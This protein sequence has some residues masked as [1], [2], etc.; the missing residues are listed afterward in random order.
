MK[1]KILLMGC[2]S[3]LLMGLVS[4]GQP[5][6][7][8]GTE[9]VVNSSASETVPETEEK[10]NE[11]SEESIGEDMPYWKGVRDLFVYDVYTTGRTYV[12]RVSINI[13][14]PSLKPTSFGWAY[15]LDPAYIFVT[16]PGFTLEDGKI[17]I[18]ENVMVESLEDTF[19]VTI[20]QICRYL[21]SDRNR[22]YS[23]FD[24]VVETA[25]PVTINDLSM[26][27]Y[28]GIH[29]YT[30]EEE[31][32]QCDFVAYSVDTKQVEH[33]YLTLIV[34][35]DSLSNPSLDPLPEGT[36]EA[37]AKKMAESITVRE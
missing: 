1:R 10:S 36:I 15:Q 7:S 20:P 14:Y 30:Y 19:E 23:N 34:L 4:C 6:S 18:N 17:N 11:T 37:Y 13:D 8:E 28:T 5:A 21:K 3:A 22:R 33:S 32:R 25:E 16:D 2:I 29:T 24:F 31:D 35:D 9:S 27:K 12:G 26:Y